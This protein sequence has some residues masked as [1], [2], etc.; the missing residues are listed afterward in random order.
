L[1]MMND[2]AKEWGINAIFA[3][4]Y[5][6]SHTTHLSAMAMATIVRKTI[7]DYPD[8]LKKTALRSVRFGSQT[9]PSTN[10][11]L[12]QYQG[13]DGFKTGTNS[14]AGA[15]FAATAQR[16]DVRIITVLMGSTYSR[17]FSDTRIL[18]DYGFAEMEARR[19]A[20]AELEAR[21]VPPTSS[22]IFINGEEVEFEAYHIDGSNYFKLRD[23][24][25]ALNGTDAQ[26]NVEWDNENKEVLITRGDEYITVGGEMSGRSNERKLPEP[27]SVKVSIDGEEKHFE[28]YMIEGNNY[29]KLRELM[30]ALNVTVNYDEETRFITIE[31]NE[32]DQV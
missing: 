31:T 25:Y 7:Q 14:V 12:G 30:G 24:A 3:S 20:A 1:E 8:V 18:L 22:P 21:K 32:P 23:L 6:G 10:L 19:A 16:G 5:G 17:R 11:L 4:T 28:I 15:C 13:I 29:F 27:S 26:F 9:L 2:K